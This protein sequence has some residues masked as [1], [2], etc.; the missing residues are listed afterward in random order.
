MEESL[1]ARL[2]SCCLGKQERC[3]SACSGQ[4]SRLSYPLVESLGPYSYSHRTWILQKSWAILEKNV[5][6]SQAC[7]WEQQERRRAS[8]FCLKQKSCLGH[9]LTSWRLW[10]NNGCFK[11]LGRDHLFFRTGKQ[12]LSSISMLY[13]IYA[14]V[15]CLKYPRNLAKCSLCFTDGEIKT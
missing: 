11:L 5:F 10:G 9:T 14:P 15:E 13:A 1:S 4:L 6:A 12:T 3:R 7:Q 2:A 8:N